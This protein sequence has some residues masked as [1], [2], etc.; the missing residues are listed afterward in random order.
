MS[1]MLAALLA[2]SSAPLPTGAPGVATWY[3]ATRNRA[4][5]TQEP[6]RGAASRNQ[7]V[8]P[9]TLYGAVRGFRWG[10]RPYQVEVCR[11]DRPGRCVTVWVVDYCSC[12]RLRPGRMAIDLSPEAFGRLGR[13]GLGVLPVTIRRLEAPKSRPE[14]P[15]LTGQ[16]IGP[17]YR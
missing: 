14:R 1:L 17:L 12:S 7:E 10:D 3:D 2:A 6:R 8:G 4:W 13:L 16:K 11:R 5:Y 15:R 9:L